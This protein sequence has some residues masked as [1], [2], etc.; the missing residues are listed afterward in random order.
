MHRPGAASTTTS[1]DQRAIIQGK[2]NKHSEI[3]KF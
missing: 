2:S 1:D 3:V